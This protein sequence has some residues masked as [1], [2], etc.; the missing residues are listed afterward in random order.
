MPSGTA[1]PWGASAVDDQA[2]ADALF[3]AARAWFAERGIS[4]LRGPANPSMNYECGLLVE[5]FDSPPT[6]MMTYNPPYYAKLI[7][8]AG[9]EK[10][11]DLLAFIGASIVARAMRFFMVAALLYYAGEPIRDFIEKRLSLVMTVFLVL[12]I[13]GFVAVKYIF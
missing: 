13:G 12:L 3:D 11:H 7:E 10:V 2:V 5:G 9:F 4:Q 6:F 1:K 8:R